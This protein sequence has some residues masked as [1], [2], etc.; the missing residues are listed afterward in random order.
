[1]SPEQSVYY[2]FGMGAGTQGS[3]H[4]VTSGLSVFR[5]S[6]VFRPEPPRPPHARQPPASPCLENAKQSREG[7]SAWTRADNRG[8]ALL[9]VAS[10]A[11][12]HGRNTDP[13]RPNT[14]PIKS[15]WRAEA[16]PKL[17]TYI[18]GEVVG[19]EAFEVSRYGLS[20]GNRFAF[21]AGT[22]RDWA[23]FTSRVCKSIR[24]ARPS[25]KPD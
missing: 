14:E 2:V 23:A 3:A 19:R 10:C 6:T 7:S 5:S 22:R 24:T 18:L 21:A 11:H 15:K 4:G 9:T 20:S 25:R 17:F 8:N 16:R 13:T 1:M 12:E